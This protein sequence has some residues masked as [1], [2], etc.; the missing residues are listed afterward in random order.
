[1]RHWDQEMTLLCCS[2]EQTVWCGLVAKCEVAGLLGLAGTRAACINAA[3]MALAD[4]GIPMRD[5]VVSCAAGYLNSTPL[6]GENVLLSVNLGF[7]Y[8]F[9][10][11]N[12]TITDMAVL[13]RKTCVQPVWLTMAKAIF[14][15]LVV[16]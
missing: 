3:S 6:L 12:Q 1:M 9:S 14:C 8:N 7:S 2:G 13:Q 5:L 4:A 11:A 15:C 16:K 10:I